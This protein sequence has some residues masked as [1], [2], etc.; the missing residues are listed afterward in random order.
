MEPNV[1]NATIGSMYERYSNWVL[2][3]ALL[4]PKQT[5]AYLAVAMGLFFGVFQG[6]IN[7]SATFGLVQG[8]FFGTFMGLFMAVWYTRM[9]KR[10]FHGLTKPEQRISVMKTVRDGSA[11][12]DIE[13]APAVI[14]Y[15]RELVK[16]WEGKMAKVGRVLIFVG[17]FISAVLLIIAITEKDIAGIILW[18]AL[19][20]L[21]IFMVR[22]LPRMWAKNI[23]KAR[24]AE[25]S[26][27][28]LLDSRAAAPT[29]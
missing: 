8:L 16:Q 9:S 3:N 5:S 28:N 10:S 18:I 23:S 26:A 15:A 1:R 27:Q 20:G 17:P 14:Q 7:R 19:G 13:L 24:A 4:K 22:R 25:A 29:Q 21:Y 12:T 6:I 11:T 2:K